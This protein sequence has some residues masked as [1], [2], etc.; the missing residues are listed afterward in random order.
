MTFDIP[1]GHNGENQQCRPSNSTEFDQITTIDF[2]AL[3]MHEQQSGD[4]IEHGQ[5][6]GPT[7]PPIGWPPVERDRHRRQHPP[8]KNGVENALRRLRTSAL[9][10]LQDQDA[11]KQTDQW[12]RD[13]AIQLVQIDRAE[14]EERNG[15]YDERVDRRRH[16]ARLFIRLI[17]QIPGQAPA[18]PRNAINGPTISIGRL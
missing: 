17:K 8:T 3:G 4:R 13:P 7:G 11:A 9:E 18:M 16:P 6:H 10:R 2:R 1:L 15:M 14:S 12:C 5:Q